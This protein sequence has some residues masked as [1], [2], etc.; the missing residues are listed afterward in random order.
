VGKDKD[1]LML[2]P[3]RAQ[4]KR[5]PSFCRP[6]RSEGSPFFF[7]KPN[8]Y[9]SIL[10]EQPSLFFLNIQKIAKFHEFESK[11]EKN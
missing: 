5:S 8:G 10:T 1:S 4:A 9:S 6:E 7:M 2:L 3:P 11:K